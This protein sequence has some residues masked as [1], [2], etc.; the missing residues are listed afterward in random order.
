MGQKET[1]SRVINRPLGKLQLTEHGHRRSDRWR[2]SR[3]AV[4]PRYSGA[5]SPIRSADEDEDALLTSDSRLAMA[6]SVDVPAHGRPHFR[7]SDDQSRSG[8]RE[9]ETQPRV[10]KRSVSR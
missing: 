9:E 2:K 3:V 5:F 1:I 4:R 6:T 10:G 8:G 7:S